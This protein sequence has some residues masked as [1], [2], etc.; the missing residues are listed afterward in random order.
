MDKKT[1]RVYKFFRRLNEVYDKL[2]RN[3][4]DADAAILQDSITTRSDDISGMI[5][6]KTDRKLL[7]TISFIALQE[8][9]PG[10][11]VNALHDAFA[12]FNNIV[13]DLYQA[14]G[15]LQ[16]YL[17]TEA[18]G[19]EE[20]IVIDDEFMEESYNSY[21]YDIVSDYDEWGFDL[22]SIAK[23]DSSLDVY[24]I[25]GTYKNLKATREEIIRIGE[26]AEENWP[27]EEYLFPVIEEYLP[28]FDVDKFL[29]GEVIKAIM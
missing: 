1:E 2:P 25:E 4:R 21:I 26:S 13:R 12:T 18:E 23:E 10:E 11:E 9:K 8:G 20:E 16:Q 17:E 19:E 28:D 7:G 29:K 5:I 15:D 22:K 27:L 6:E 14:K 24:N 3:F